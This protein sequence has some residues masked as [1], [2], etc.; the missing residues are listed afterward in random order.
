MAKPCTLRICEN[1]RY[2]RR[3]DP[4]E[5]RNNIAQKQAH[6]KIAINPRVKPR[7]CE[8]IKCT[9]QSH[10]AEIVAMR[11]PRQPLKTT[12]FKGFL[13]MTGCIKFRGDT[14]VPES[15]CFCI[16]TRELLFLYQW[17]LFQYF[18]LHE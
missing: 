13:A 17:I 7:H 2:Q 14:S 10:N 9:K 18:P 11:L 3:R 4:D 5:T 1:N 6:N 15:Y 8:K 16:S 12:V